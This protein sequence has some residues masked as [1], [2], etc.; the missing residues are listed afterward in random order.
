LTANNTRITLSVAFNY[1]GRWD[2]VQ[3]CSRPWPTA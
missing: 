1:G 3:A 2:I